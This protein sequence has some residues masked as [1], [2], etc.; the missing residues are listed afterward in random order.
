LHN[1]FYFDVPEYSKVLLARVGAVLLQMITGES[2]HPEIFQTVVSGFEFLK[3]IE[4]KNISEFETLIVLRILYE[5]GYVVKNDDTE[6][7]LK[8]PN[9]WN[10]EILTKVGEQKVVLV[11]LINKALKE[12]QL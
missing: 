11:A 3:T 9:E 10:N 4:K 8:E 12:S 1:N 2:P 6:I 5:L 7:F